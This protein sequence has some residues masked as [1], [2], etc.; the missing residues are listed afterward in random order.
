MTHTV[1]SGDTLYKLARLYG[2]PWRA[3][4]DANLIG[5]PY[6]LAVGR[7]LT[8]PGTRPTPPG[9][10]RLV[11]EP[12]GYT[13]HRW[14]RRE[15]VRWLMVHDPVGGTPAGTLAYL[16][17]NDRQVS[18]NE[19]VVPGAPPES[20]TLAPPESYVGHAGFGTAPDGTRGSALNRASWGLC[21]WKAIADNGPF[22]DDLLAA[23][24]TV[25]ALRCGQWGLTAD[26]VLAHREVDPRRRSDP[27]GLDM[28]IFREMVARA[29]R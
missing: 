15:P 28:G 7:V 1:R 21:L 10:V 24:V 27:R 5:A 17:H 29:L 8:I 25:A 19:L 4:A 3:I 20:V 22:P 11:D 13:A 9:S 18:Y 6:L 2:V 16:R 14:P 26:R 12:S 23:A